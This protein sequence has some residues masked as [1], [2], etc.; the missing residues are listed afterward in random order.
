[1]TF[2]M[3]DTIK[4]PNPQNMGGMKIQTNLEAGTKSEDD[5][6]ET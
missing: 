1:M 6:H 2:D 3:T 5:E 4:S